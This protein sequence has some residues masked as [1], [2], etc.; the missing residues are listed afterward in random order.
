MKSIPKVFQISSSTL[1]NFAVME[2]YKSTKQLF[3]L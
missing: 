3:T 1:W 2:E